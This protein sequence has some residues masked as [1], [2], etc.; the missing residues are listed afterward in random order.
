[1]VKKRESYGNKMRGE[2]NEIG[3]FLKKNRKS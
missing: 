1:M 3:D 2:E